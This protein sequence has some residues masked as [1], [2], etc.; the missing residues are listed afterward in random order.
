LIARALDPLPGAKTIAFISHDNGPTA[1]DRQ[2]AIGWLQEGTKRA[3][4]RPGERLLAGFTPADSHALALGLQKVAIETD[5][6]YAQS[7]DFPERPMQWLDGAIVG[8]YVL[9]VDKPENSTGWRDLSVALTRSQGRAY[10]TAT[11]SNSRQ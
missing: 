8:Y 9:F 7:L 10:A 4:R 11:Y 5:G 1:L 2:R 6:F 3:D